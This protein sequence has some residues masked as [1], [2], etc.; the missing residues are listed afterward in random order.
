M[1]TADCGLRIDVM[2]VGYMAVCKWVYGTGSVT[3][4]YT[5]FQ[6]DLGL[7]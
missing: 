3:F 5:Q 4:P 2:I 1:D 7:M 6:I